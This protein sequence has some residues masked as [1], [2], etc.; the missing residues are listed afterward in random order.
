MTQTTATA[1]R[2]AEKRRCSAML[3]NDAA[4]LDAALDA[5]LQFHH[6]NGVVDDKAAYLAKM[7][8]GRIR[9]T[10]IAWEEEK[11]VE[12][13]NGAALLTGKMITDVSVEGVDKRLVNRAITVWASGGDGWKLVAFQ[14][15]P[16]AA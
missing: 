8:G 16:M 11:V 3:A 10:G 2:D 4:E 6:S 14:S 15:T 13:G 5:R 7:A 12:L 1:I 9:Y